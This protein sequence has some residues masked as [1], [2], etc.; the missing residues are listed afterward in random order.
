MGPNAP[1]SCPP[2][3]LY[4]LNTKLVFELSQDGL[5]FQLAATDSVERLLQLVKGPFSAPRRLIKKTPYP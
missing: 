2:V 5:Q 1:G 3:L 4:T